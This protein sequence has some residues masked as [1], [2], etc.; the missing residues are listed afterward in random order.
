[1]PLYGCKTTS[2]SGSGLYAYIIFDMLA[3]YCGHYVWILT[4]PLFNFNGKRIITVELRG[5]KDVKYLEARITGSGTAVLFIHLGN[6]VY[7]KVL[8][9]TKP[10]IRRQYI[11][12]TKSRSCLW[13][14]SRAAVVLEN[15]APSW[16]SMQLFLILYRALCITFHIWWKGCYKSFLF[17]CLILLWCS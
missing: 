6:F 9:P 16:S 11:I 17:F 15:E 13:R 12:T 5:E 1:M 8:V 7:R 2:V 14:R 10:T 3:W 4:G